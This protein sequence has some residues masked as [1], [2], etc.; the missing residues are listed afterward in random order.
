MRIGLEVKRKGYESGQDA[1]RA[2]R[3]YG[4]SK[5]M[6]TNKIKMAIRKTANF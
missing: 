3:T 1:E 6:A 2:H 4:K 5:D